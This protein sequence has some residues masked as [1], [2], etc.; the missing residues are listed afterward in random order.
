MDPNVGS[1]MGEVIFDI[2]WADRVAP[3]ATLTYRPLLGH[4][5]AQLLVTQ[6]PG[7]SA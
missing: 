4:P 2:S 7:S 6:M 1:Q 5:Y 3:K